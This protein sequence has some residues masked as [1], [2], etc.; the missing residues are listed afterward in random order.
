MRQ[1]NI[2]VARR[3]RGII[4]FFF[5]FLNYSA[6]SQTFIKNGIV[7]EDYSANRAANPGEPGTNAGG[8]LCAYLINNTTNIVLQTQAVNA[9][10]TYS[11]TV[12]AL[13]GASYIVAIGNCGISIGT[14][15]TGGT[16]A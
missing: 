1:I 9:D 15:F 3:S 4:F 12:T 5:L 6:F 7:Y 10:G 14:V 16:S 2:K 8:L 11:F 13:S